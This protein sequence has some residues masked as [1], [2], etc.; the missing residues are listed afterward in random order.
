MLP[1]VVFAPGA[2]HYGSA[3]VSFHAG[4]DGLRGHVQEIDAGRVCACVCVYMCE[5]LGGVIEA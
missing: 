4:G 3:R 2:I 5:A 1:G